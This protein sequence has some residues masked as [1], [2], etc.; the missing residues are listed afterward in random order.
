MTMTESLKNECKDDSPLQTVRRIRKILSGLPLKLVEKNL[1]STA[2]SYTTTLFFEGTGLGVRGKGVSRML[3]KASAYGE[4][5][6]RLQNMILGAPFHLS[7]EVLAGEFKFAPD[8]KVLSED[9]VARLNEKFRNVYSVPAGPGG[10]VGEW[11]RLYPQGGTPAFTGLPFCSLADGAIHYL[12]WQMLSLY[13]S[14]G[15]CAGNTPEEALVQGLSE[16]LERHVNKVV[17]DT[18]V[19]PPDI[20]PAYIRR[21]GRSRAIISEIERSGKYKVI[22]KDCSL[23]KGFPVLAVILVSLEEQSY[24]VNFGAH[25]RFEIA[26]ERCLTEALQSYKVTALLGRS[27]FRFSFREKPVAEPYNYI[28]S[29]RVG[30]AIYP[31]ALFSGEPSYKFVPWKEP[32]RGNREKLRRLLAFIDGLG[33]E[34]LVRDKS[35]LGFPAFQAVIPG[36]SEVEEPAEIFVPAAIQRNGVEALVR[37][38]P[39]LSP[40][41]CGAFIAH[42]VARVPYLMECRKLSGFLA[43]PVKDSFPWDNTSVPFFTAMLYYRKGDLDRTLGI[44]NSIAAGLAG[45]TAND[46]VY[47]KCLRDYLAA[48]KSGAVPSAVKAV[49]RRFYPAKVLNKVLADWSDPVKPLKAFSSLPCGA[50]RSCKVRKHCLKE[51]FKALYLKLKEK[52]SENPIDQGRL[53]QFALRPGAGSPGLG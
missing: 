45:S 17:I 39:S 19:T 21:A 1:K 6:E 18:Q 16:I 23:G 33:A 43:F 49:L 44:I 50:C 9:Y 12:P 51:D 42:I 31:V 26:L 40:E 47:I 38:L 37:S 48:R 28:N 53:K 32:G 41:Q 35:F 36:L 25:P 5:M 15:M 10:G 2:H 13:R 3:S 34:V 46:G 52:I 14:N 30:R 24:M 4:F 27:F 29:V 20:P 11:L 22:A 8:E 7:P